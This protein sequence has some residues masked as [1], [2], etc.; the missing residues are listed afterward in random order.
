MTE[1]NK[2][3]SP[4]INVCSL[5]PVTQVC[6]GCYRTI[7]EIAGWMTYTDDQRAAIS[8]VLSARRTKYGT[9]EA[10]TGNQMAPQSA[11]RKRR[12]GRCNAEFRCGL[13]SPGGQCWCASLPH[14]SPPIVT[15]D[16]CLCPKCLTDA[17]EKMCVR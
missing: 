11:D 15:S 10:A 4:C 2:P 13:L 1:R 7:E 5:D 14:T 3:D 17:I 16:K 9:D 6:V 8:H 12:C